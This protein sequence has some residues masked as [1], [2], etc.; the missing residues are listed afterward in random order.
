[1]KIYALF[2]Y[3]LFIKKEHSIK[4][5]IELCYKNNASYLQYRDKIN[6]Q[7]QKIANIK[8]IKSFWDKVLIINDDIDLIQYCDG[9]HLG[10]EDLR[11]VSKNK[12][13]AIK[14]VREKIGKK[15]FGISTH[16]KEEV[17]EANLLDIDYIGLGAYRGTLTKKVSNILGD[18]IEVIASFSKHP[19]AA[20]GGVKRDDNIKNIEFLVL[21]SGLYL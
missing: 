18:E 19:V 11:K 8:K 4:Q 7:E 13:E 9:L 21:G 2:D 1:M 14:K 5:F 10:Q 16:N 12:M 15:I 17:L 20:I 3:A 6:S